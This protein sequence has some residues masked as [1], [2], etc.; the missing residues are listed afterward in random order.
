MLL[1][2]SARRRDEYSGHTKRRC[3]TFEV[4]LA[5]PA[6]APLSARPLS[7]RPPLVLIGKHRALG[8]LTGVVPGNRAFKAADATS[9]AFPKPW[10]GAL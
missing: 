5:P 4:V 10:T 1:K 9:Q 8:N 7:P 2:G 3:H 6:A